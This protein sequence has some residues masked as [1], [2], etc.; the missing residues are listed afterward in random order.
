[1]GTNCVIDESAP[2][3]HI[4]SHTAHIRLSCEV[5]NYRKGFE[6]NQIHFYFVKQKAEGLGHLL[7]KPGYTH[8]KNFTVLL[9]CSAPPF[10]PLHFLRILFRC[11]LLFSINL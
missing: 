6:R 3:P 9:T 5:S 1:M 7:S 11:T 10:L 8:D 4:I 2:H